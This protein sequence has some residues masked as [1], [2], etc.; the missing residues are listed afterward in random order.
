VEDLLESGHVF[1]GRYRVQRLIARGGMGAV[2]AAEQLATDLPVALKVLYPHILRSPDSIE[3]FQLEA[4]VAG[5]VNSEH[6][7]R[8]FDAGYDRTTRL[9][10]L[11]MELLRGQELKSLVDR[12][13]PLSPEAV[14]EY[15]RQVA[16]GL[17][18]A[19]RHMNR[20]G[21][22]KPIIHR[23][24]KPE[25]LFVTRRESGE[26]VVKILDFGLAKVLGDSAHVSQD[27]KGTPL[28]MAYEQAAGVELCPETD[29]W[30]LGLTTFYLLTGRNYWKTASTPRSSM[31][32]LFGEILT[33]PLVTPT[34]R[35]R[36]LGA[37]PNW[38]P[39]FDAWFLRCLDRDPKMRFHSAKLA[40]AELAQ[41][42]GAP[43]GTGTTSSV[44]GLART[45]AGTNHLGA[46]S[47]SGDLLRPTGS[48]TLPSGTQLSDENPSSD[49]VSSEVELPMRWGSQRPEKR[50]TR[51]LPA[52]L[53]GVALIALFWLGFTGL[54]PPRAQGSDPA[55]AH[56]QTA[57]PAPT[58]SAQP[59]PAPAPKAPPA[60]A[61]L[62]PSVNAEP[63]P[64]PSEPP[65]KEEK[66]ERPVRKS[67][68]VAP[69][70]APRQQKPSET[71]SPET[72]TTP[73]PVPA[74]SR[75]APDPYSERYK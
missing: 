10:F 59:A 49:P 52:L 18:R 42:L 53:G 66:S 14:V 43:A 22:H 45:V 32:S 37:E 21:H 25:N 35:I 34:E 20:D 24:L 40:A 74:P 27:V 16:S 60:E 70:A 17:E 47:P 8:V 64:L 15:I 19:H 73:P 72:E 71:P 58:E 9:P 38:P 23:D 46:T 7:V 5:R 29:I 1:A 28:F 13:G 48:R 63:A 39:A 69:S 4:K 11:V 6:I 68:P 51:P 61:A 26:P 2:Y 36:E 75:P 41:A 12:G 31:A 62:V 3:K 65:A 56:P 50:R 67:S 44:P 57:T 55:S 54:G 30:S 33:L